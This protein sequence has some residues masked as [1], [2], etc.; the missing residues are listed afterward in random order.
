M[1]VNLSMLPEMVFGLLMA[2]PTWGMGLELLDYFNL[3]TPDWYCKLGANVVF[4]LMAAAWSYL[5][6]ETGHG[7]A[8]RM[9]WDPDSAKGTRKQR[10][11]IV[12]DPICKLFNIE[13][14]GALYC[15]LFMGLKG[16]LIGLPCYPYGLWLALLWPF[17]YYVGH[18]LRGLEGENPS[19]TE[20]GEYLTGMFSA[21]VLTLAIG[22]LS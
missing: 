4:Y 7:I 10:L 17:S 1:P 9:G 14:G 20:I 3:L 5:W 22:T 6:M 21:F 15:W 11:S 19:A 16:L 13:L 18:V 12:I 2:I 8:Y